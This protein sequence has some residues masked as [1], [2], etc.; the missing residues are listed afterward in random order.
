MGNLLRDAVLARYMQTRSSLLLNAAIT[1]QPNVVKIWER[2]AE[3]PVTHQTTRPIGGVREGDEVVVCEPLLRIGVL[4][5]YSRGI[6]VVFAV[7]V[8][9]GCSDIVQ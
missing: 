7:D 6:P 5:E 1:G 3:V 8:I 9:G 4:Q 2:A